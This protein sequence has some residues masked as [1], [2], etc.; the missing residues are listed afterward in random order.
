MQHY[1]GPGRPLTTL[2]TWDKVVSAAQGGLLEENQWCELKEKVGAPG[3]H[4]NLELARDLAS[5]SIH[6]GVLIFGVRDK[7]FDVVGCETDGLRDRISQVA[8]SRVSPPLV[9]LISDPLEG[10]GQKKLLVVSVP[11]SPQAP[12]MVDERYFGRS[13]DGKRVLSDPEIRS[14]ILT[15]D[16]RTLGFVQR[17]EALAQNDPI[18]LL[19]E[20][21]PTGHGHAFYLAEP[22]SPFPTDP[23]DRH[24]LQNLLINLKNGRRGGASLLRD[25]TY[26]GNDPDGVSLRTGHDKVQRQYEHREAQISVHDDYRITA[27]SGGATRMIDNHPGGPRLVALVGTMAQFAAQFLEMVRDISLTQGFQGQWQIGMHATNLRGATAAEN[28]FSGHPP[29]YPRDSSTHQLIIH[30]TAWEDPQAEIEQTAVALLSKY[31]RGLGR[32]G[33]TFN[34]LLQTA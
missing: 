28:S 21:A 9:P 13:A 7:T 33:W 24:D 10:P 30:P 34:N 20:D 4:T 8:A 18:D 22:A 19:V 16:Q 12:H 14:L 3:K 25:C 31:L 23:I 32:D 2:D 17:L 1:L 15:R 6:G 11:P 27:V 5:L 26:S 29:Q